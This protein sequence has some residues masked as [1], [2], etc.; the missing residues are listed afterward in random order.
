MVR[1]LRVFYWTL[2]KTIY[3]KYS[4]RSDLINQNKI[5]DNWQQIS[6]KNI[7]HFLNYAENHKLTSQYRPWKKKL[8]L[9]VQLLYFLCKE[10]WFKITLYIYWSI[11]LVLLAVI[12][13][14]VQENFFPQ[15]ALILFCRIFKK[16]GS[17]HK[18]LTNSL[19]QS[20]YMQIYMNVLV[21]ENSNIFIARKFQLLLPSHI[22]WY[23]YSSSSLISTFS[24]Y[25][26]FYWST[27][28]ST[29]LITCTL[30]VY[31]LKF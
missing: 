10:Q 30:W 11:V 8:E 21:L 2:K 22:I 29:T 3:L 4:R 5:T 16:N 7:S 9:S 20:E 26:Y 14:Q 25:L 24:C 28:L 31:L 6:H 12:I 23:S 18:H 13:K 1:T 15:V 27:V 19:Q 17:D